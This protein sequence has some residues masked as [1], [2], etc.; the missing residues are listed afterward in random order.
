MWGGLG[1]GRGAGLGFLIRASLLGG[2]EVQV[3]QSVRHN[4]T[5]TFC[6]TLGGALAK[7]QVYPVLVSGNFLTGLLQVEPCSWSIRS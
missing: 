7:S 2:W 5:P 3:R 1:L 6:H 4:S